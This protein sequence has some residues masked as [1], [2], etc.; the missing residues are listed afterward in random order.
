[1]TTPLH[2]LTDRSD[3]AKRGAAVSLGTY[4][5]VR[6]FESDL[7]PEKELLELAR[8]ELFKPFEPE[9]R[10]S[11]AMKL[12]Y[13]D[14]KHEESCEAKA[15]VRIDG[16]DHVVK[17]VELKR[18]GEQANVNERTHA[19]IK[20][21]AERYLESRFCKFETS[22]PDAFPNDVW[23]TF[24]RLTVRASEAAQHDW[25]ELGA[26]DIIPVRH[27]ATCEVCGTT[28]ARYSAKVTITWAGFNLV[29]EYMLGE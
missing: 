9:R 20:A 1:M 14:I 15:T 29:R 26:V 22:V 16:V 21:A 10:Y 13:T 2:P 24:Q 12:K 23:K 4:D 27:V 11:S 7:L 3:A 28:V 5:Q 6:L 19:R 8:A 25:L 17:S 18:F